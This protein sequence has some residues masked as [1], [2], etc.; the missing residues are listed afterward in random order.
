[1]GDDRR[2]W[3]WEQNGGKRV[4]SRENKQNTSSTVAKSSAFTSVND[5]KG[6]TQSAINPAT[7]PHA[8]DF[9]HDKGRKGQT[10]SID[11]VRSKPRRNHA[12]CL[13][14]RDLFQVE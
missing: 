3:A 4:S 10:S 6:T 12:P 1:M 9:H 14:V 2:T 5:G 11:L 7:P 8:R 13:E